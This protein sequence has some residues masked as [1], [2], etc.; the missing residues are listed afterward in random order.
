MELTSYLI[1]DD[2]DHTVTVLFLI[3]RDFLDIPIVGFNVIE[4]KLSISKV[5]QPELTDR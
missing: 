1:E 2:C 3:T 5:P 4:R